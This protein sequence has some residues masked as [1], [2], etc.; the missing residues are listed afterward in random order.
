MGKLVICESGTR[1]VAHS[2]I[3]SD[4]TAEDRFAIANWR[5][6]QPARLGT[7]F[8]SHSSRVRAF[9]TRLYGVE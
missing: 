4:S 8:E 1:L 3:A 2:S 6:Q 5:S 9:G 7:Q